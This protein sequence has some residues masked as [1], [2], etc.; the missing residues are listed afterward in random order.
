LQFLNISHDF[1]TS[2]FQYSFQFSRGFFKN[3]LL[4][5]RTQP[6]KNVLRRSGEHWRCF[7]WAHRITIKPIPLRPRELYAKIPR[8]RW[9]YSERARL[10]SD[11]VP[12][13]IRYDPIDREREQKRCESIRQ[14]KKTWELLT[15]LKRRHSGQSTFTF[16]IAVYD[17]GVV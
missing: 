16:L 17:I 1:G 15:S 12:D 9:R 14:T 4:L 3:L 7:L 10:R 2:I 13:P 6:S 8:E 5:A 11:I